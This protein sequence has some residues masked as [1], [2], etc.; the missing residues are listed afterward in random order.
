MGFCES[1]LDSSIK[2][3][4]SWLPGEWDKHCKSGAGIRGVLMFKENLG[5][6]TKVF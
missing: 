6:R 4:V 3:A 5:V 1:S 2:M